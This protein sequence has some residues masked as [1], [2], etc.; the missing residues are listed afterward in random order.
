MKT[1]LKFEKARKIYQKFRHIPDPLLSRLGAGAF[2]VARVAPLKALAFDVP[3]ITETTKMFEKSILQFRRSRSLARTIQ[4]D[5]RLLNMPTNSQDTWMRKKISHPY[6]NAYTAVF[7][8][9]IVFNVAQAI[10]KSLKGTAG[11]LSKIPRR[12][13]T[14]ARKISEKRG[15]VAY[16]LIDS[17]FDIPITWSFIWLINKVAGDSVEQISGLHAMTA[18]GVAT[19]FAIV[20]SYGGLIL[21]QTPLAR[22][23]IP[24]GHF[25]DFVQGFKETFCSFHLWRNVKSLLAD[26]GIIKTEYKKNGLR[27]LYHSLQCS[28]QASLSRFWNLISSMFRQYV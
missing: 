7:S 4:S 14:A 20:V 13:T 2:T 18:L 19:A 5:L 1:K 17:V 15:F 28:M 3:C 22:K 25:T 24:K 23:D 6:E 11:K 16:S 9:P 10:S 27:C 21:A 12:I 26:M 8:V